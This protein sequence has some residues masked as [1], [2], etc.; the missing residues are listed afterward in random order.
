M[1]PAIAGRYQIEAYYS[2][3]LVRYLF[4]YKT[5]LGKHYLRIEQAGRHMFRISTEIS[6]GLNC[7]HSYVPRANQ[8]PRSSSSNMPVFCY[9]QGARRATLVSLFQIDEFDLPRPNA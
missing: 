3:T 6:T 1:V 7:A 5:I 4:S 8:Q 9:L 2:G